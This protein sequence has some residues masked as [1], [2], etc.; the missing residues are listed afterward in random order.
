MKKRMAWSTLLLAGALVLGGGCGSSGSGIELDGGVG[1]EG[2]AAGEGGA[3]GEGG[4]AG[5][6][7]AGGSGGEGGTAE[8]PEIDPPGGTFADPVTVTLYIPDATAIY[9]TLDGS[10]P[11][12]NCLPYEGPFEISSST[13]LRYVPHF[14]PEI[15]ELR[16]QGYVIEGSGS[17]AEL[18]NG[19]MLEAWVA[20]ESATRQMLKDKYFGGCE[21]VIRCGGGGFNLDDLG[22]WL[23]CE[24]SAIADKAACEAAGRGWIEW[25]VAAEGIGGKSTFTYSGFVHEVSEG[26]DLRADSGAIVGRFD[27]NGTGSTSTAEGETLRLSGCHNGA[28]EDATEVTVREKTGGSYLVTCSDEGCSSSPETYLIG[29]GPT[30][31]LFERGERSCALPFYLIRSGYNDRC[32]ASLNDNQALASV[33]C[34]ADESGQRWNLV[35]DTTAETDGFY[36]LATP[37]GEHCIEALEPPLIGFRRMGMAA[38]TVNSP[39]QRFEF[40]GTGEAVQIQTA[41]GAYADG[42][43]S[44]IA[45]DLNQ[46]AGAIYGWTCNQGI[47]PFGLFEDGR[48]PAIDPG[49]DLRTE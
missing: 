32:L 4:A 25:I 14:G 44:C 3:G 38:C 15:G 45:V 28:I 13:E 17:G 36:K 27:A 41:P 23:L 6:A 10:D 20:M 11:E 31:T 16:T 33:L 35:A 21:P 1:G 18:S 37:S 46:S 12:E 24:D 34:D 48:F 43:R 9:Y 42:S 47:T 40:H 26:C 5:Q 49:T 2:G 19:V 29:P 22:T 8:L 30:F 39:T 7:G